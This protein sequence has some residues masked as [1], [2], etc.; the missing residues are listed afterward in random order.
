MKKFVAV[1]YGNP[2]WVY[3]RALLPEAADYLF[4]PGLRTVLAQERR[5]R[6]IDC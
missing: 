5:K 1:F 3:S 2:A 4:V 6:T